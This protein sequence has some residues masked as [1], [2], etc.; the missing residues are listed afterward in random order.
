MRNVIC[1]CNSKSKFT[2]H[3]LLQ[4]V[5]KLHIKG[6][7]MKKLIGM[8]L[9]G[10]PMLAAASNCDEIS[11]NIAEKIKNNGVDP[12][13][14]QLKLESVDKS[15]QQI[16]GKIVGSC[17]RGQQHIIYV[18]LDSSTTTS[19]TPSTNA[20]DEPTQ[21]DDDNLTQP[22]TINPTEEQNVQPTPQDNQSAP[23]QN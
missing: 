16:E 15:E 18:R 3:F 4:M 9:L 6:K 14:F 10:L 5:V 21:S 12:S 11:R 19:Q 8:F 23:V 7:K 13:L 2:N 17:D 1:S 20:K 22:S